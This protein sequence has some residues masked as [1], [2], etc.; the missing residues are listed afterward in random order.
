[1]NESKE[2]YDLAIYNQE[3]LVDT[4][5]KHPQKVSQKATELL[6]T[7]FTFLER[8]FGPRK[9]IR[10]LED[11]KTLE[12]NTEFEFRN[13]VLE[14]SHEIQLD[15]LKQKYSAYLTSFESNI[16]K[17]LISYLEEQLNKLIVE[18]KDKRFKFSRNI[19]SAYNETEEFTD[20]PSIYNKLKKSIEDDFER[21]F[22]IINTLIE[23]Y[24]NDIQNNIKKYGKSVP[25]D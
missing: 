18:L 2:K 1:M 17:N 19:K 25:S 3:Q 12:A 22:R 7:N 5:E 9:I 8:I 24:E 13:R 10:A 15:A 23:S 6:T 21:Y 16:K 4:I 20:N 11:Q 14:L